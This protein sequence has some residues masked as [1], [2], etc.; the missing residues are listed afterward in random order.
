MLVKPACR[1]NYAKNK[2]LAFNSIVKEWEQETVKYT[3]NCG[4]NIATYHNAADHTFELILSFVLLF[5]CVYVL[6]PNESKINKQP[7]MFKAN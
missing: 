3:E 1:Y 2:T 4:S 7:V 6:Q 5:R